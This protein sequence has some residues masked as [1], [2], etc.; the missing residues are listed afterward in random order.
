MG[1]RCPKCKKDF[2]NDY[3]ALQK[4][5]KNNIICA[6]YAFN[7]INKQKFERMRKWEKD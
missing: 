6:E 7:L 5:F 3:K 2:G 1:Y 4:H